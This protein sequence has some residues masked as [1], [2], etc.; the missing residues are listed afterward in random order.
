MLLCANLYYVTKATTVTY[1]CY[2]FYGEDNSIYCV[3]KQAAARVA[4]D[5][6]IAN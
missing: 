1:S 5:A 2:S 6:V 4:D 3:V